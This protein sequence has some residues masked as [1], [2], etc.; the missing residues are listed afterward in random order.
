MTFDCM[1][2][3]EYAA[4]IEAARRVRN[5]GRY[6][7]ADCPLAYEEAMR[8]QGRCDRRPTPAHRPIE[9]VSDPKVARRRAQWRNA[10]RRQYERERAAA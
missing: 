8:L 1:T 7:C 5:G 3:E 6:P 2:P 4:W 10:K 9:P